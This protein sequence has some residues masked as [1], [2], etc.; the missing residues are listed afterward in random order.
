[1]SK[2]IVVYPHHE[3]IMSNT[4]SKLLMHATIWVELRIVMLNGEKDTKRM[5]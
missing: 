2:Q 1:M 5:M 4:K 3:I